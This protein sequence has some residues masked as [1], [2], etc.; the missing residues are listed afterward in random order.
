VRLRPSF[1]YGRHL[2]GSPSKIARDGNGIWNLN[3]SHT[4]IQQSP[5]SSYNYADTSKTLAYQFDRIYDHE[6]NTNTIYD[7]C[8]RNVVTKAMEGYHGSV[9]SYGQTSTGKTY[10][11]Q[12]TPNDPGIVPLAVEEAFGYISSTSGTNREWLMRMS[13][14]EIYNEQIFDLLCTTNPGALAPSN[15]TA[16]LGGGTKTSSSIK[17]RRNREIKIFEQ[18]GKG[19][20]IKNLTEMVVI[21]KDQVFGLI[22]SGEAQRHV[23]STQLNK[24]SSR[25]HTIFRLVIE[26]KSQFSN[27]AVRVSTL[28]LVDLAGSESVKQAKTTGVRKKEGHYI[29]KSLL[30]LGHVIWKLS[31][32]SSPEADAATNSN[33]NHIPYR[34]SKLTRLLQP[35]LSGNAHIAIICNISPNSENADESHNTLKFA[36]RAKRI[37]STTVIEEIPD[38]ATLLQLY[39]EEIE[40]LK[41]QL[42]KMRVVEKHDEVVPEQA[43]AQSTFDPT[44]DVGAE[45]DIDIDEEEEEETQAITT[46]IHNLERLILKNEAGKKKKKDDSEELFFTRATRATSTTSASSSSNNPPLGNHHLIRSPTPE[47][48]STTNENYSLV[49]ELQRVQEMLGAVLEKK[50]IRKSVLGG[51]VTPIRHSSVGASIPAPTPFA[52]PTRGDEQ[53][54]MTKIKS[55]ETEKKLRYAD[56]HFLERELCEKDKILNDVAGVLAEVER[57]QEELE[58]ENYRLRQEVGSLRL[59]L[60][61]EDS[62]RPEVW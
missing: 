46:A 57:Q 5:D 33:K 14:L 19:V 13:Y 16:K 59:Q 55:L 38:D 53:K 58:E 61:S 22:Q 34:D 44:V 4:A 10:T 45:F 42:E 56:L 21:S 6:I 23:G 29:N 7:H 11:M 52:T 54:L 37:K 60:T 41:R 12:G 25:S 3:S 49:N 48:T 24:N 39:K 43:L 31:E 28:S 36:S 1:T 17:A 40:G 35:S 30:T 18:K 62:A 50:T 8:C 15:P 51:P 27:S 32:R 9:F 26:S 20:V 47:S 2:D